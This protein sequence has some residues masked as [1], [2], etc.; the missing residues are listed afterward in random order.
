MAQHVCRRLTHPPTMPR[1]GCVCMCV[2]VCV[3][4]RE[5]ERVCVCVWV[6]IYGSTRCNTLQ[7]TTT[8]GNTLQHTATHRHWHFCD[9]HPSLLHCDKLQHVATH[10][11]TQAL[12]FLWSA[13]FST[14]LRQAATRCNTLQHTA[15]HCSTLQHTATHCNTLQHTATQ[16]L[17]FF[18]IGILLRTSD[19]FGVRNHLCMHVYVC[20]S[21]C[22]CVCEYGESKCI[23]YITHCNTLYDHT[24]KTVQHPTKSRKRFQHPTYL[25]QL[26]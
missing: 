17:T 12:T 4:E 20:V 16:T 5:A 14:T 9:Q 21:V 6:Y 7:H 15:K 11:N 13:S 23:R 18:A 8:H 24:Y 3:R 22:E 2:C 26:P 1:L 10:C 19:H 25:A